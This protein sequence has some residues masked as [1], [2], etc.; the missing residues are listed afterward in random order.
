MFIETTINLDVKV[1]KRI[2]HCAV[3]AQKNQSYIIEY[4]MKKTM[5]YHQRLV[6]S[7]RRIEYQNKSPMMNWHKL[8]VTFTIRDYEYF[9]DMR[10]LCKKSFSYLVAYS[11][12]RYLDDFLKSLNNKTKQIYN[13]DNYQFLHYVIIKEMFDDVICWKIY[14][15]LPRNPDHLSIKT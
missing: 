11:V 7:D 3:A 13:T 4:L 9:L 14:W 1:I 15:G 6:R 12:D 8:H 2:Q 10:K 5:K